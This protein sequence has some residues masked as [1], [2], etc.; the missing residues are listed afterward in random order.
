M[1][2]TLAREGWEWLSHIYGDDLE[3]YQALL[4]AYYMALN[5]HELAVIISSGDQSRLSGSASFNSPFHFNV[6]LTFMS[7]NQDIIQRAQFLLLRNPDSVTELWTMLNVT[8]EQM[9]NSWKIWVRLFENW[10]EN[11]YSRYSDVSMGTIYTNIEH[12]RVF[13]EKLQP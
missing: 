2:R 5:I 4:V 7:E 9:E 6:P 13:F 1:R 8:R 12:H 3:E 10:L 11:V